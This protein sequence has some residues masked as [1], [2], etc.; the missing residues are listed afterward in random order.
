MATDVSTASAAFVFRVEKEVKLKM[1]AAEAIETSVTNSL[2][3]DYTDLDDLPSPT[4]TDLP[5]FKS[6]TF[7]LRIC[8]QDKQ[9]SI[10]NSK[11]LTSEKSS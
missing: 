7:E 10:S 1:I 6:F 8:S 3:Q 9:M 5:G 2:S 4:C 11:S